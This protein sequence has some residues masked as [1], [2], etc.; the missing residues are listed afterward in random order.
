MPHEN[1]HFLTWGC[2]FQIWNYCFQIWAYIRPKCSLFGF[3][4]IFFNMKLCILINWTVSIS[5]TQLVSSNSILKY[6]N[7]AF[8]FLDL[9]LAFL[10]EILQAFDFDDAYSN[11]KTVFSDC[12]LKKP[13]QDIFSSKLK[14]LYCC[15]KLNKFE[16]ADLKYNN[17]IFEL[18]LKY[19]NLRHFWSQNWSMFFFS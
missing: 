19:I 12:N 5:D 13:K 3:K 1:L 15:T 10:H 16:A 8:L 7:K 18:F 4:Y 14:V 2:W 11:I 6:S 9:R 17:V